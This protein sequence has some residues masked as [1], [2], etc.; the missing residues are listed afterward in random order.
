MQPWFA[1][2]RFT[3]LQKDVA[4]F[5]DV[6]QKYVLYLTSQSERFKPII[7]VIPVKIQNQV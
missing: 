5:V 4:E 1:N 7:C 3:S 2:T 6:M